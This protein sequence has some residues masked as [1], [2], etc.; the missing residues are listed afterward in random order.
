M[1]KN[2][3]LTIALVFLIFSCSKSDNTPSE[4]TVTPEEIPINDSTIGL[5]IHGEETGSYDESIDIFKTSNGY[6][7]F[8]NKNR[9]DLNITYEGNA[10]MVIRKLDN[11]LETTSEF[12]IETNEFEVLSSVTQIDDQKFALSGRFE[13]EAGDFSNR[14]FFVHI[15]DSDG[16][17]LNT[18]VLNQTPIFSTASVKTTQIVFKNDVLYVTGPLNGN[19]SVSIVALD[20]NLNELW[21]RNY[22]FYGQG[23]IYVDDYV[24]F[25]LADLSGTVTEQT[26]SSL[27]YLDIS[28]GTTIKTVTYDDVQS[29]M[30]RIEKIIPAGETLYLIGKGIYL[31]EG[32]ISEV[33][34]EDG[35]IVSRIYAEDFYSIN[36]LFIADDGLVFAG[37][38]KYNIGLYKINNE[39]NFIWD[40]SFPQPS[41]TINIYK[42]LDNQDGTITISGSS[43]INEIDKSTNAI[44]GIINV[45]TGEIN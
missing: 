26:T 17:V 10:N 41:R 35:Q 38:S 15:I 45:G 30:H 27:H 24:Y 18:K 33:N 16:N 6:I 21:Q 8:E 44:Y 28:N 37:D 25:G 22:D 1:F 36:D 14:Y 7:A 4:E 12:I 23:S 40:I 5:K 19:N 29:P 39:G 11:N 9:F 3:I 20:M 13:F 43:N 2:K 34:K 42:L 32:Y 31:T